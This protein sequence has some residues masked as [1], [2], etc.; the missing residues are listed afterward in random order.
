MGEA[1]FNRQ[2]L[3]I[4]ALFC[5]L[6]FQYSSWTSR[7]PTFVL[8]LALS[9]AEVGVLLLATGLG[10]VSASPLIPRLLRQ[11]GSRRLALGSAAVL[12]ALLMPMAAISSYPLLVA[13]MLVDGVAVACLNVAMNAQGAAL[14]VRHGRNAMARLHAT[15]SGGA[16]LAALL[17][18][19]VTALDPGLWTHFTIAIVALL[20]L[21]GSAA[22]GLQNEDARQETVQSEPADPA[23]PPRRRTAPRPSP[24]VLWLG[25]AMMFSTVTE[26]AMNDWSALFLAAVAR[27]SPAVVPMGIAVFSTSMV[28][29]RLFTDG[30]RSRWGDGR[31]VVVGAAAASVGLAV[32]LLAG[33]V[34]PALLGFACV[35]LGA[36]A[37]SPC[38]Y[39]A[40]AR[41][42]PGALTIVAAT[43]T[44]GLLVGP[45]VIGFVAQASNLS[46]GLG[47]VVLC[48]AAV[49][50]SATRIRW[51]SAVT[52]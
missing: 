51:T 40:A 29:A 25:T 42:G 17:A 39:A 24:A 9:P 3:A 37:V 7:L 23:G 33:G 49:A 38:V 46:W 1:S 4:A 16:L 43:D 47:T 48:A 28:L 52:P 14:E 8:R 12:T 6:G 31:V 26:G 36:A 45:P 21:V 41:Q 5:A 10:A 13:I 34:V 18:S 35:G 20:T 2:L 11:L 19:G 32:A 30:W 44:V 27:A 15:F 50:L 22:T